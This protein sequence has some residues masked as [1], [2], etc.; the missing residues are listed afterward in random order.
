MTF[1]VIQNTYYTIMKIKQNTSKK[2]LEIFYSKKVVTKEQLLKLADCSNMTAWRTL[3]THGYFSSYNFN[4]KYYTLCDIPVF[5]ENGLWTYQ[6]IHFSK[7][8]TVTNTVVELI[9]KSESGL[10]KNELKKVC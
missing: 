1:C 9:N 2:I 4:A 5:D 8:K 3:N 7:Y 10:D 6:K